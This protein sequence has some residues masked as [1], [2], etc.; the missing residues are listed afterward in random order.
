M[1]TFDEVKPL[2]SDSGFRKSVD[3]A[4]IAL[5]FG[6]P[7]FFWGF[8]LVYQTLSYQLYG[9]LFF[10]VMDGM[11]IMF[12]FPIFVPLH[13]LLLIPARFLLK[14]STNETLMVNVKV[15]LIIIT[16]ISVFPLYFEVPIFALIP[17]FCLFFVWLFRKFLLHGRVSE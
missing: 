1:E 5:L 2:D 17:V 10:G 14:K 7:G 3:P 15:L 12:L 8:F 11:E 4:W 9:S 13:I 6:V 16:F